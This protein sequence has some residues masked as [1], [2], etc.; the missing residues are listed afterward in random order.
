MPKYCC[1]WHPKDNDFIEKSLDDKCP[2]CGRTYGYVLDN[3]PMK[4]G[5]YVIERAIDR[6][7][8]S[9]VYAARR[10][11]F[12]APIALKVAPKSVYEFYGKNFNDECDKHH[13]IAKS[14]SYIINIRDFIEDVLTFPD[15]STLECEI[16]EL[17]Y[18]DGE[19]LANYL[20]KNECLS[21]ATIG[22]VAIDLFRI[23]QE[24]QQRD[25][26]HNDLHAGNILISK[27]SEDTRRLDE[28]IDD[29]IKAVV[30]DLGSLSDESKSNNNRLGDIHWVVEH[31]RLLVSK[32]VLNKNKCTPEE[33][34]L[35]QLLEDRSYQFAPSATSQ[36]FIHFDECVDNINK[37]F[38]RVR[39]SWSSPLELKNL[40][41]GYNA[42]SL[43]SWHVPD[44][45]VDPD[46]KWL[47]QVCA[48]GP[49]IITGMRGCGKTMLLMSLQFHARARIRKDESRE[50]MLK[51]ISNDNFV[52]FYVNGG[53]L[54]DSLG[55]STDKIKK[56]YEKLLVGF[57]LDATRSL[58]HLYELSPE[59]VTKQ[60]YKIIASAISDY[61]VDVK[62]LLNVISDHELESS[63]VK[64]MVALDRDEVEYEIKAHPAVVFAHLAEAVRSSSDYW[65]KSTVL[66]LLDDVSTRYFT[67]P[68]IQNL[69]S[70]LLFQSPSCAFK[71]TSEAQ[72]LELVLQSPGG[73][74][75]ARPGRDYDIFDLGAEVLQQM[76][77]GP[78]GS[79]V[80]FIEKILTLRTEH[81]RG[82]E[83]L[84]NISISSILG[85]CSLKSI[86]LNICKSSKASPQKK[87]I[88]YGITALSSVC[89]GDIGDIIALY[90]MIIVRSKGKS[91]PI[92]AEIQSE[93]Y[94]DLCGRRL[95][96]L[97]RR[98]KDYRNFALSF[99][100]A[101]HQL[102]IDSYKRIR[103]DKN[104][105]RLR[106]YCKL[107][108]RMTTSEEE[109]QF[110]KIRELV[111]SGVFVLEGG[112]DTPRT[113]TK[114]SDPVRQFILT[115]RKLF[116]LSSFIGLSER[117]RFELSGND[118]GLWL[119]N[120]HK[121]KEVLMRN[122]SPLIESDYVEEQ[123][124]WGQLDFWGGDE[125]NEQKI[126]E[127][128][129]IKENIEITDE[130]RHFSDRKSPVVRKL[131]NRNL[132]SMNIECVI[133]AL[134]F[135]SRTVNSLKRMFGYVK[136]KKITLIK[137]PETGKTNEVLDLVYKNKIKNDVVSDYKMLSNKGRAISDN[138]LIDISGM[139]QPII[140]KLVKSS[141]EKYGK[142]IIAHTH[143]RDHYPLNN[144]IEKVLKAE[145]EKD[146]YG[147]LEELSRLLRGETGP[148]RIK[149]LQGSDADETRKR[150]LCAFASAKH[151]RLL[152]FLD[153]R[154]FDVLDLFLIDNDSP[155]SK[156]AALSADV[157]TKK[158]QYSVTTPI[159][160][161]DLN[162]TIKQLSARY[163][164]WFVRGG[165]NLELALT[166]SKIQAA[167][168]AALC[169]AFKLSYCW[170]VSPKKY[171]V[172]R[173]SK[174]VGKTEYFEIK[175]Q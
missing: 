146:H 164:Q 160:T 84:R 35:A 14:A 158:Y 12:D 2:E 71:I 171:D 117:D 166:G 34:R 110:N 129:F 79:G 20:N 81:T 40:D 48:P 49:Q 39:T 139:T 37:T 93:C 28:A 72:T 125:I 65:Y 114:D 75:M 128:I 133:S 56:P 106:Q 147:L 69:F 16:A 132:S 68:P 145:K 47:R 19:S 92:S 169:A 76:K 104:K 101:S 13:Q 172:K 143:A 88:Y 22:Q 64:I 134:G 173:F 94:Q 118:L 113:K 140:F 3:T 152:T 161:N 45:I 131:S 87:K 115:Y 70:S 10:G 148:Y 156:L 52:G 11:R 74:E 102:L 107:Y 15:G 119:K 24:L 124:E 135:E 141:L 108:V 36:R 27:L 53:K 17:D 159:D 111:D 62:D 4:I 7:F 170:Y 61:L 38:S 66:F 6:G 138:C 55:A 21:A 1:F 33:V 9:I 42:Q 78:Q 77:V 167:A 121:G 60:W 103:G 51:R 86:S 112:S 85:N 126:P 122:L 120:P 109:W 54:L 31:L 80:N 151:E 73:T 149:M 41:H 90:E 58:R 95:Y 99:A 32:I 174:G 136:P 153:K 144:D 50:K 89:V 67:K 82:Y 105:A 8:Y 23:L 96:H 63:L 150:I 98:G 29:R 163:H 130:D 155:R 30:V 157:A 83:S 44:L 165:C 18:I 43:D 116:G 46:E 5:Q 175:M 57:A 127:S 168:S 59:S 26:N 97:N 162:S 142:A 123:E 91:Y 25:V 100:E 154:K 137:Y